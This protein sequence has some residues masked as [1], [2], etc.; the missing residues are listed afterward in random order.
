MTLIQKIDTREVPM[1]DLLIGLGQVRTDTVDKDLVELADSIRRIG[2]LEPILVS[3]VP[4]K[5]KYEILTG[6]RRFLAHKLLGKDTIT[7]TIIKPVDMTTAKA[8]SLTENLVRN[9]LTTRELIDACTALYKKYG[10]AKQVA[11]ETGLPYNK[12]RE[13]IKYDRLDST[14]KQLVD[15]GEVPLIAALK[16]QDATEIAGIDDPG[17][18]IKLA[19]EMSSMSY[20]QR[21]SV[22]K[23]LQNEPDLSINDVVIGARNQKRIKQVIVTLAND[24]HRALQTYAKLEEVSQDDAAGQ[25]IEE[26]L[27][28]KGIL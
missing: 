11:E 9:N 12:V 20:A 16:A 6:Q 10:S 21:R 19:R 5:G 8:I 7:A 14:L 18:K 4:E 13:Y 28:G 1:A 27:K 23:D 25:L 26:G 24:L 15:D 2:L 22:A 3:E 17:E